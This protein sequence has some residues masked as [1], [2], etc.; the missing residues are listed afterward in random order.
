MASR[1][2]TPALRGQEVGSVQSQF[3]P[4]PF[5]NLNPDA[6]VFGAGQARAL[7]QV[8]A[9]FDAL[10]TG[11][12]KLAESDDKLSLTKFETAVKQQQLAENA[13]IGALVGQEQRDAADAAPGA[14]SKFV[15]TARAKHAFKLPNSI[16]AAENFSALSQSQFSASSVA[17]SAA[18]KAVVDKQVSAS[19]LVTAARNLTASPAQVAAFAG[20]VNSTVLDPDI[21]LAQAA[22]LN[23]S[24]IAYSGTDPEKVQQKNLLENMIAEQQALGLRQ[25]VDSLV[26]KGDLAGAVS[27]VDG[28]PQL[29][30]NTAGRIAAEAQVATFRQK[31]QA[32]Q[33]FSAIISAGSSSGKPPTLAEL[34]G[35]VAAEPDV[36]KRS[37]L[38]AEFSVYSG[39]ATAALNESI[40]TQGAAFIADLAAGQSGEGSLAKYPAYFAANPL[41]ALGM[42][43][44]A[45]AVAASKALSA[46]D[47]AHIANN[48]GASN[49]PGLNN[50][51]SLMFQSDPAEAARLIDGNKLKLYFDR[52]TYE[53][54]QQQAGAVKKIASTRE[55]KNTTNAGTV[56]RRYLG[57]STAEIET[58][59]KAAGP[60]LTAAVSSVEKAAIAAGKP[61]DAEDV[62]KVVFEN[63]VKI[64]TID[65][66]AINPRGDEY[67]VLS[68]VT[69]AQ[70]DGGFNPYAA[71]MGDGSVNT[72]TL[73]FLFG[74]GVDEIVAARK[75]LAD[76]DTEYSMNNLAA[77]FGLKSPPEARKAAENEQA[78][79]NLSLNAG[80]PPDFVEYV[81]KSL[82]QPLNM[83][84]SVKTIKALKG[85]SIKNVSTRTLLEA[86][87]TR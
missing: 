69:Q 71:R 5:Q 32:Q 6:D 11:L 59:M 10:G 45:R 35:T 15:A 14:F 46:E 51:M 83:D 60:R 87:A 75:A 66:W 2:P 20:V 28:N 85:G 24:L 49:V 50:A 34:Y 26:A 80:Y 78:M 13:R 3:T 23:P 67:T 37:R 77:H 30:A 63:L 58:V 31:V 36:N 64:R 29:G 43:A 65:R 74:K 22:G 19:R 62:R 81:I 52:T 70:V 79:D 7:G 76:K 18:G 61:V 12:I 1:I 21:G 44:K 55:S 27:F 40:K 82:R 47:A 25:V 86:W 72:R 68:A 8:S 39:A 56:M 38:L 53:G 48:G 42:P 17:A 84:S 33:E 73:A 54:L 4:T 57:Y 41:A 16:T 9:G